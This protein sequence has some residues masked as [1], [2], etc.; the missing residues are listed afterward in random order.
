MQV[1]EVTLELWC[2][3]HSKALTTETLKQ[4]CAIFWFTR[5]L[6]CSPLLWKSHVL[7]MLNGEYSMYSD[8]Y[9]GYRFAPVF[10][11]LKKEENCDGGA[12]EPKPTSGKKT[13]NPRTSDYEMRGWCSSG[14][15]RRGCTG[16][17]GEEAICLGLLCALEIFPVF[18][19]IWAKIYFWPLKCQTYLNLK[20][21]AIWILS[22]TG[23][24]FFWNELG[25]SVEFS[26]PLTQK[27]L[28]K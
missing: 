23:L 28:G 21:G 24:Q 10:M 15:W 1:P 16:N 12:K 26:I 14:V 20:L 3:T 25:K 11:S 9:D 8:W 5:F 18:Q 7:L 13:P 22:A 27:I 2:L 19:L 4:L 6:F 17:S